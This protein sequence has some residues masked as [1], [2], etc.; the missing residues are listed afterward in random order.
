MKRTVAQWSK[1]RAELKVSFEAMG[2]SACEKC[3]SRFNLSFAHRFKR[4]HIN[5]E[6]EMRKVALLCVPCHQK[7]EDSGHD[8]MYAA[9]S[10]IIQK[11]TGY[12]ALGDPFY[13]ADVFSAQYEEPPMGE[14][15]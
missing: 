14:L 7:I 13:D 15:L 4:R 3:A 6:A 11:R 8:L 1:I 2:I 9:I 12:D 5:D 10:E